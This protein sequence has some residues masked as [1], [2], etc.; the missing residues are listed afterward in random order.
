MQLSVSAKTFNEIIL[1][2]T[3]DKPILTG[4]SQVIMALIIF[5]PELLL[6]P[7]VLMIVLEKPGYYIFLYCNNKKKLIRPMSTVR[8]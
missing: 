5:S 7:V 1:T 6:I 8:M 4:M 2:R 3:E